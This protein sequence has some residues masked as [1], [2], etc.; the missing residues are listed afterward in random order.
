[1]GIVASSMESYRPHEHACASQSTMRILI[2]LL[3][4]NMRKGKV[5]ED[6][7]IRDLAARLKLE[8]DCCLTLAGVRDPLGPTC[9][10]VCRG[11][12]NATVTR[13]FYI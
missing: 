9:C 3:D 6:T 11:K 7:L 13:K 8:P 2:S 1:L 12:L 10:P 4:G 5:E